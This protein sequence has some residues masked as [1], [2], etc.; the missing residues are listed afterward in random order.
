MG[1]FKK[2][3][4]L[5]DNQGKRHQTFLTIKE[6]FTPQTGLQRCLKLSGRIFKELHKTNVSFQE[7]QTTPYESVLHP[8]K[9]SHHDCLFECLCSKDLS[10]D[11]IEFLAL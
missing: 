9:M 2:L 6:D 5:F 10:T 4:T 3:Y 1:D 8:N 11:A 7:K